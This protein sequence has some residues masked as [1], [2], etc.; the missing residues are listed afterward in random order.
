MVHATCRDYTRSGPSPGVGDCG[1]IRVRATTKLW[2][3]GGDYAFVDMGTMEVT[4]ANTGESLES[5]PGA[6]TARPQI[7]L[8]FDLTFDYPMKLW[9]LALGGVVLIQFSRVDSVLVDRNVVSALSK[10]SSRPGRTDMEPE[11]WWLNQLNSD[12][13]TLNPLLCAIEADVK[14]VPTLDE[15]CENLKQAASVLAEGLPKAKVLHHDPEHYAAAYSMVTAVAER[16]SMEASFLTSAVPLIVSR[17]RTSKRDGL[18]RELG[19]RACDSGIS[20]RSF[21]GI[22]ALSCLYERADG[23]GPM[24]GRGI[25]KPTL[26]Y[27]AEDAYNALA[28]I[29]ALEILALASGFGTGTFGLCTHDHALA[30]LWESLGVSEPYWTEGAEFTAKLSPSPLLFPGLDED[31]VVALLRRI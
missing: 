18:E 21:V 30:A 4:N 23:T 1:E 13:L 15:F 29:N 26:S 22:C 5:V 27:S 19:E 16:R 11:R 6:T 20:V 7:T 8:S 14:R 28:D 12:R 24:I 3:R 31:K 25:I 17:A 9:V 2:P 10:L